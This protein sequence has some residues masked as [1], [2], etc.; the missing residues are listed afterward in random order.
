MLSGSELLKAACRALMKLTAD[1]IAE[2]VR[3]ICLKCDTV[4]VVVA[5]AVVVVELLISVL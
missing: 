3:L 1:S 4:V 5:V 2:I